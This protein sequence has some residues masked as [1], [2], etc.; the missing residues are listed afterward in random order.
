MKR[1]L[2]ASVVSLAL[3]LAATGCSAEPDP[4]AG[5]KKAQVCA[6]CHGPE[7]RSP[8]GQFPV[9]AGQY[10]DYLVYALKAYRSGE[11]QDPVMQNFASNLSDQDIRDIAAYF[12]GLEGL[13]VK[14]YARD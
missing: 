14:E 7:G 5:Q 3:L 9:L 4:Q 12:A 11:R 10:R 8:T 1:V 6:S 2:C 13:E